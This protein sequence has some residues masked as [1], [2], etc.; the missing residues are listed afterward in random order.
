MT[1]VQVMYNNTRSR[2]KLDNNFIDEFGEKVDVHQRSVLNPLEV[3]SREF[4]FGT[5]WEL[6]HADDLVIIAESKDKLRRKLIRW[7]SEME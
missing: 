3:L 7:K 4:R 1:L 6:V 2:L 5:S